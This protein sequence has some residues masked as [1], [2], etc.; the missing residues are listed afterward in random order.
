MDFHVRWSFCQ[1]ER[2]TNFKFDCP[3]LD[4]L[5]TFRSSAIGAL[6]ETG[7][8]HLLNLPIVTRG[9]AAV[10]A[11]DAERLPVAAERT[12]GRRGA[13][14]RRGRQLGEERGLD[15]GL[16]GGERQRGAREV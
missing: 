4:I 14:G 15:P 13:G 3:G 10:L 11:A 12:T 1:R 9:D 8:T 6:L 2:Q 16:R 7:R 5:T